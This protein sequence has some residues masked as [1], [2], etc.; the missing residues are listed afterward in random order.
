MATW[1]SN[2]LARLESLIN[3]IQTPTFVYKCTGTNDDAAIETLINN[4]FSSGTAMSMKLMVSGTMGLRSAPP[5]G[6]HLTISAANTR[7]AVCHLD[8]SDC[9][10]PETLNQFLYIPSA[11]DAR[12]AVTGLRV[13]LQ[14]GAGAITLI[15]ATSKC[16][17]TDCVIS[18][19]PG[20]PPYSIIVAPNAV[21]YHCDIT[22]TFSA[23]VL[24]GCSVS[25]QSIT[26]GKNKYYSCEFSGVFS[27]PGH[28]DKC[29]F[30]EG[31]SINTSAPTPIY[32]FFDCTMIGSTTGISVATSD[33]NTEIK[34]IGCRIKGGVEDIQQTSASSVK[35]HIQGCSFSKDGIIV[36]AASAN[37]TTRITT[38]LG[39]N[40]FMP[41]YA[42]QFSRTI[43]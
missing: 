43:T 2:E 24:I 14:T 37:S 27:I 33:T 29:V 9:T 10:V 15:T 28:F 26:S 36:D 7:G 13:K 34:L 3:S 8:F 16:S 18:K 38:K 39:A 23:L 21:F 12:I 4:F 22:G 20:G 5:S 35:W 32:H 42:N 30:N 6:T 41:Q 40:C 17:F 25:D 11:S 19:A 1:I 31:I